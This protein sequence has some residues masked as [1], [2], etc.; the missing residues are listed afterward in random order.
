MQLCV[1]MRKNSSAT[2]GVTMANKKFLCKYHIMK[3]MFLMFL[4]VCNLKMR[5]CSVGVYSWRITVDIC[6]RQRTSHNIV[7]YVAEK[8]LL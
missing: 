1:T 3:N 4:S 7:V 6:S 8:L 5:L 2:A